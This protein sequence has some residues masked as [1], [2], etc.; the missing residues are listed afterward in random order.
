MREEEKLA[1]DVYLALYEKWGLQIFK[2]ISNSEQKHT[3]S[4]KTLIDAYNLEDPFID[5]IGEFTNTNLQDLYRKLVSQGSISEVE[6]LKVGALIED[7]D[8][9]DLENAMTRTK[10]PSILKVYENLQRGSRNH[11]RSFTQTLSRYGESYT[12]SYLSQTDYLEIINSG[13]ETG[14]GKGNGAGNRR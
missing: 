14:Q 11:I 9:V 4:L 10:N 13:N 7:L 12:P 2:N 5:K 6:A 8:I 1:R 3:D